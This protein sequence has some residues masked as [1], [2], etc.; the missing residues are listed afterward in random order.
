LCAIEDHSFSRKY[1]AASNVTLEIAD[2]VSAV[3]SLSRDAIGL[4]LAEL[5][6]EAG[7]LDLA[8]TVVEAL[9][10]SV[11][12]A[13]SLA[14]LY[15]L[16]GRYADVVDLT[17]GMTNDDNPTALLVT[18]RGIALREQGHPTA[19]RE[20]FGTP[21]NP[22]HEMP[23]SGTEPGRAD[24]VGGQVGDGRTGGPVGV[25]RMLAGAP[26]G[27][28]AVVMGRVFVENATQ[29]PLADDERPVE[30]FPAQRSDESFAGRVR[31]GAPAV[32][33]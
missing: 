12:A 15:M 22:S 20:A 17:N 18:F 9:D 21:S 31:S 2:G 25:R 24:A 11:I 1:L 5:H 27:P 10:P 29:M 13:V 4:A 30:E 19:A 26:V 23:P 6:Q 33:W 14:E 3:L 32:A 7:N 8:V 28:M 16:T